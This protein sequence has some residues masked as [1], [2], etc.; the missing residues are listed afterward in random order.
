MAEKATDNGLIPF[1]LDQFNEC[2]SLWNDEEERENAG[3]SREYVAYHLIAH[4][5]YLSRC[6]HIASIFKIESL[7]KE[8]LATLLLMA[9]E[10][11]V[12]F[13][14][15]G[16]ALAILGKDSLEPEELEYIEHLLSHRDELDLVIEQLK[17][18]ARNANNEQIRR[19]VVRG[20]GI[21]A[22][23]DDVLL[24]RP[25][26][27][28]VCSRSLVG[29]RSTEWLFNGSYPD[30]FAIARGW[31]KEYESIPR[32][33]DRSLQHAVD[34]LGLKIS[35]DKMVALPRTHRDRTSAI[36]LLEERNKE[37]MSE[38]ENFALAASSGEVTEERAVSLIQNTLSV[39]GN[40][41]VQVRLELKKGQNDKRVLKIALIGSTTNT[42]KIACVEV[43]FKSAPV[44]RANFQ[45]G[46]A[47]L[48]LKASEIGAIV[49][50][51]IVDA[52]GKRCEV[53]LE[54]PSNGA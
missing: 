33:L 7:P 22:G 48:P 6:E 30:W 20:V 52:E 53:S 23:I 34:N 4:A 15:P 39:D 44:Q 46:L 36:T 42:D 54:G 10:F 27:M 17:R 37:I 8:Q 41:D 49:S 2:F 1:H 16:V 40:A 18:F 31:D 13:D 9:G 28:S 29:I 45:L 38:E 51:V 12:N 43:G 25:D 14:L 47:S 24:T 5:A 50:L 35:N 19:L 26:I 11:A 32:W 21:A 3:L